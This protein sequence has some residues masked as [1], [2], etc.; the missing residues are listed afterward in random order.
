MGILYCVEKQATRKMTTDSVVNNVS[1]KEITWAEVSDYIKTG[2]LYKLRR[3]VQQNVGY[4]KHKAA[5]VGK[6][7]TEFIIDKLQWNQQELIELN[8]V[9][10]PTKEDK[11]HAC[12]L[13]KNLYKVAINDFP[14]FFE[15]NVVHLLVWS[16][17]RIPI[18]EDDKTG[19]KEVRINAT[20]NVFPEFNEEMRLKIEAFLKSVLTDRYGIKRENYGWFIN[21]TNL[22]SI[23]GIS[24]IHL[25]L[26]I[27]DK[28]ELSHMDAFIKELME[29]FEPK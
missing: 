6:D 21:Y 28:D 8:E 17:I 16:K 9:K 7:I 14:Y 4:R 2:E 20:D 3:S 27:T 5:L 18:Y 13:H 12:F 10:Y 26:R 24:H 11:I 15:S 22:Q 23:R 29:N 19:E 1:S 25:L